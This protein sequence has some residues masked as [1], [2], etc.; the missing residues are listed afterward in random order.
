M[1]FL[2]RRASERKTSHGQAHRLITPP[3]SRQCSSE[4][5]VYTANT[6]THRSPM[7]LLLLYSSRSNPGALEPGKGEIGPELFSFVPVYTS[8]ANCFFLY[9]MCPGFLRG[10]CSTRTSPTNNADDTN[11]RKSHKRT[12]TQPKTCICLNT[13]DSWWG[14]CVRPAPFLA[15]LLKSGPALGP[16]SMFVMPNAS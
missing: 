11:A 5:C 1:P 6:I 9:T 14:Q 2:T 7:L 8:G 12:D 13:G 4:R 16:G 15:D 10:G 3:A